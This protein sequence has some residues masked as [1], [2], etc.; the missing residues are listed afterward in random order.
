MSRGFAVEGPPRTI[1][2]CFLLIPLC[3]PVMKRLRA[4]GPVQRLLSAAASLPGACR[5][6]RAG[7]APEFRLDGVRAYGSVAAIRP[8]RTVVDSRASIASPRVSHAG[9]DK[10][11]TSRSMADAFRTATS[12]S[13]TRG[14]RRV[15]RWLMLP[16]RRS[17][18]PHHPTLECRAR[19]A[20]V[21]RER[22]LQPV[23]VLRARK[24][25]G[26]GPIDRLQMRGHR[27]VGVAARK[28]REMPLAAH[29][30][31]SG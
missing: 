11:R 9:R 4:N 6:R 24:D 26:D 19:P 25:Q 23:Q 1:D 15:A 12:T 17:A 13:L 8:L 16:T 21:S 27:Q 18:A 29:S 22:F 20:S 14:G 5:A 31:A 28:R 3:S 10:A 2:E 30:R 7:C